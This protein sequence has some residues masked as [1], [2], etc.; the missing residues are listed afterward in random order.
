[1]KAAVLTA[2]YK[3]E[4]QDVPEPEP[5]ENEVKIKVVAS[6]VCGSEVHAYKG[7]HPF[8]H[9]PS[10]LGHETAGDVVAVGS[11]VTK[12]KIG[13]RVTVEPQI[14]CGV[15][16]YCRA[17]HPNLCVDKVVLG[18]TK[19]IGAYAEY[20][21]APEQVVYRIPDNVAYDEAV[22]IEPLAVGVHA[23]RE[24][25]LQLGQSVLILG[26]GTIGLCTLAAARA[27]GALSTIVTDAVDFNL[28][29]ARELGATATVNVRQ[30]DLKAVVDQVTDGKG[31]DTAFVTVGFSPVVNQGLTSIKKRGQ[32]ILIAL[33][34]GNATIDDPFTIVGGER[35]LRGSQMYTG[36]DV[37]IAVDLIGSGKVD[38]KM[39]IT[40][41]LPMSEAQR[42]FEI[43]DKKLEDCVKV[44]LHW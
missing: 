20:F 41:H 19:W 10:I 22:M 5:E 1:M 4:M 44:V 39:F 40:Q 15:C 27:A 33:F 36:A 24:A 31:V 21:V 2:H 16:D 25:D 14:S 29:V 8:R 12:F 7:T 35:V 3:I 26:G 6:G 23:V 17:G 11:A 43:V 32:V 30:G 13:D 28:A 38:A 37:Q 18:T 42:G 9:P 34:A